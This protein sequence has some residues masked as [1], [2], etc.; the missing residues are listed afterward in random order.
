MNKEP[1]PSTA[2]LTLKRLIK[3]LSFLR[4]VLNLLPCC[5]MTL[6]AAENMMP[7]CQLLR[8]QESGYMRDGDIILGGIFPVHIDVVK[9]EMTFQEEP[10]R[11]KCLTFAFPNYQWVQA[12]V[13]AIEEINN[14]SAL[15]PNITLG[16]QIY[17]TC[18]MLQWS[19][20][21]T[22]WILSG[23]EKPIPNYRCQKGLP[24]AVI[25]GDTGS[26]PSMLLA[27]ILGLYRYPQISYFSTSPLL[28]D[29]HQFPSFFRTVP[30]DDFQ[31]QG[32]A[33][34]VIHF[35][36]TWVGIVA[37]DDNYGL[38][39]SHL[40]QQE[41]IKAGACVAFTENIF[42]SRVDTNV[43]HIV[44]VIRNSTAKAIVLSPTYSYM[45][46][47]LDELVRQNVTGKTWIASESWSTYSLL[48][49]EKYSE[50]LTGTI[51]FAICSGEMVGFQEYFTSIHPSRSS[52]DVF[53]RKFWEEA[54]G[55][56]WL[57]WENLQIVDN[58]TKKCTGD[59]KLD[60]LPIKS[61][62]DFRITY[63]I[64]N[65][66][67]ATVQALKDL[68]SC[69]GN[70]GSFF[71]ETCAGFLDFH[72]WQL[73][74]YIKKVHL[75][76]KDT[77]LFF[78][79]YGN[80]PARFDIVNWQRDPKGTLRHVKV[81]TYDANALSGKTLNIN[82][83]AVQ[84]ASGNM[85]V[86][87]SVCSP[88]CPTGF[89][90]AIIP[91]KPI[92]CFQCVPCLLGDIANQSD[93]V[94]CLKYPW[95]QWSNE[96]R[97]RCIPKI[98][99]FLSYTEPFGSTLAATS[100]L[101][102]VIPAVILGLFIT[103]RKTPIIRAS[104]Y[105]LSYLLL[106]SLT[107]CFLC[108]LAFVGFPTPVKC[109]LRQ[110]SFGITF[111]LCVS[112]ILA[113]TI[114]VVIAFNATKPN[115]KLRRWTGP[116]LSFTVIIV[117]TL[118]QILLCASWL[119]QSPP[120]SE[121]NTN[122]QPGI[123]IVECNEGSP[124]AFWCMLGYLWLLATIS[125][126]VAFLA[127]KLPDNFNEAKFITFSMLAFLSVWLS[128]IP[129][130]L[131]TKGKFIVAMEIF[132]ILSSSSSLVVCIFVPKIYIILFRPEMNTKDYLMGRGAG[133]RKKVKGM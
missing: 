81:G 11:A 89:R 118:F 55:C 33:Q 95:D 107:L 48:S 32:L 108:S 112:C 67:Y 132:A 131:S 3:R 6:S 129:A 109:L 127:R 77:E 86:P 72:P 71:Q 111:A 58:K 23:Q 66:V 133:Q 43:F 98:I 22:L 76:Q 50:V 105:N 45:A 119:I 38:L 36:W 125:F 73:F 64:Y 26:T 106:M 44:Q 101:S 25:I 27:H 126:I 79:R 29:R 14:S 115:S 65:A 24:P 40:V 13:F 2:S 130:Y 62:M 60:S 59:E 17:D 10:V 74:H 117:C 15:L 114:M 80:I 57:D 8:V 31:A 21:G 116:K 39:S 16:F 96:K 5:S 30:S 97:D 51:G 7:R 99:E 1:L 122:S 123:I 83:S 102:S 120:F 19:L 56:L 18:S 4:A 42:T 12:M 87:I 54:F 94:E 53:V 46:S 28:S 90:K 41:I 84:W 92:C 103:Y 49:I 78:D 100:I 93:S 110:T 20:K 82:A 88:R 113:R 104:N 61:M 121:N 70:G 124:I 37:T 47:L 34:L 128:F 9:H 75:Q 85:Q 52:G 91:G 35:G 63:N 68:M 69:V